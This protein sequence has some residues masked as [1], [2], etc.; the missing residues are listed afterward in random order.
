MCATCIF[1]PGNLMHLRAGRVR[2]MIDDALAHD[3]AIV[4][5]STLDADHA[6]CRGFFDRHQTLPLRLAVVTERI[7]EVDPPA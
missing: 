6:V 3:S 1:R 4:C 2:E 5:H 7:R